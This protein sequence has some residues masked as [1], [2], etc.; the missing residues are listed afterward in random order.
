MTIRV[1][2]IGCGKQADAHAS[3]I[4][5]IGDCEIVGACDRE[6]LMAKQLFERYPIKDYFD[7]VEDML[8][9]CKP[10]IVHITTPPHSHL[11]LGKLCIEAG[12]HVFF[13]KPFTLHTI[14]AEEILKLAEKNNRK[15]TVGHNNQF[16]GATICMR[17][18]IRN[19]L[20]GGRPLHMESIWCYDLGDQRFAKSF[21]SDA[22]HWL[23]KLPGK[24]LHNII[25]HGIAKIAEYLPT[26]KPNVIAKGYRSQTLVAIDEREIIDELRVIIDDQCDTTAYFTFSTQIKPLMRL[27]RVHGRKRSIAVDDMHQTVINICDTDYKS[28]LNHVVP[29]LKY[30]KQYLNSSLKNF[31]KFLTRDLHF[32][33]GRKVLIESFYRSVIEDLPPPIPYRE[34]LL[35]SKIMD[36]IF[37]QLDF[38]SKQKTSD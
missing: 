38:A 24:L 19:G 1:A 27:F 8:A 32:E 15:V 11:D 31:G 29:P 3:I 5:K 14:Q 25:N 30:A 13:E 21:L 35:T 26:D 20:L 37:K 34:I 7:S 12:C 2:I 18:F 4:Q 36:E 28:Y 33:S 17:E 10:E 22:N 9:D 23:R 6:K 16:N